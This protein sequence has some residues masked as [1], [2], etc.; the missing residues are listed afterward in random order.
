VRFEVLMVINMMIY[1]FWDVTPCSWVDRPDD[2]QNVDT[3]L[4]KYMVSYSRRV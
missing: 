2:L 3:S 1:T 4:P